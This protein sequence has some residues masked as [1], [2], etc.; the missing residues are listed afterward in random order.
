MVELI[1][2]GG[3]GEIGGNKVLLRDD[4]ASVFLDFGMSF[5]EEG[6]FFSDFLGPK[7]CNGIEDYV[8]LGLLPEISGI[9]R[10]DFLEHVKKKPDE[11]P[12]VDGV[13]ISHAHVD[14]IGYLNFLRADIPIYCTPESAAIME[15]FETY[16]SEEYLSIKTSFKHIE[17]KKGGLKRMTSRDEGGVMPKR[18]ET[19]RKKFRIGDLKI[20]PVPVDHSLPGACAY[21]IETSAGNIVYTGDLRFHGRNAA[22]SRDFVKKA[23][24]ARPVLMLCEGTRIGSESIDSEKGVLD[25]AADTISET[26]ALSIVNYPI[27]DLDR[28]ATFKEAAE[29]NDRRLV[30]N[31]KQAMLLEIFRKHKLKAPKLSECDIYVPRKSWGLVTEDMPKELVERDYTSWERDFLW[32]ENSITCKDIRKD[33]SSYVWRCDFFELKE[34]LDILP[35]K[36]S[37]YVRS[38]VEPFSE[39]MVLSDQV[40]QNWLSHFKIKAKL[41]AHASGHASGPE[42]REMIE[43]ISPDTLIPIHTEK[44]LLFKRFHSNVKVVEKNGKFEL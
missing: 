14:H 22:F 39:D 26:K 29:V 24:K 23:S 36:G 41:Q 19:S 34:L 7:K 35:G 28:M 40:V 43:T 3:V 8:R 1:F 15:A 27:R 33:E 5:G 25:D 32:R 17:A 6:V 2:Y 37:S 12:S 38:I 44:P 21:I 16:G 11:T 4:G 10:H 13:L 9:Y 20:T 31:L 42:L 18:V 30:L